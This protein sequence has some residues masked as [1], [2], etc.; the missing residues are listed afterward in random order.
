MLLG[1]ATAV[2]AFRRLLIASSCWRGRVPLTL[3]ARA[4]AHAI[5]NRDGAPRRLL[6]TRPHCPDKMPAKRPFERLPTDVT[7][8]NYSLCLKPDLIDFTFEGKL[9]ASVE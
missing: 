4:P 5:G 3:R 9:E 1:G 8:E 2:L 6:G 7:P